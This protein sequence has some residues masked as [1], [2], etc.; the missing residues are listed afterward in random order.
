MQVDL[1]FPPFDYSLVVPEIGVPLLTANLR[2]AKQQVRQTDLN[3]E[4]IVDE[5][6]SLKTYARLFEQF[7][8][9][10]PTEKDAFVREPN[11]FL[12][13][14]C[15]QTCHV[16]GL[17]FQNGVDP[18]QPVMEVERRAQ[19]SCHLRP[20]QIR[21][22]WREDWRTDGGAGKLG[23]LNKPDALEL[24]AHHGARDPHFRARLLRLL[25]HYYFKPKSFYA[26]DLLTE[27]DSTNELLEPFYEA[28][29][30][31]LFSHS[32][33]DLFGISIWSSS[34]L[35]PA[36]ILAR[37]VKRLLPKTTLVAGGTWCSYAG[38]LITRV[39][40]LFEFFDGFV[41]HEGDRPLAGL[42]QAL[43]QGSDFDDLPGV[44]TRRSAQGASPPIQAPSS[45]ESLAQPVY[46]G[47]PL[48][49]YPEKRLVLRLAR[50]CYW[51]RCSMCSHIRLPHNRQYAS[52]KN[53]GLSQ[54][55]LASIATHIQH[56]RNE[57]GIE[58]FTTADNL[59]SPRVMLQLCE[60]NEGLQP[61]FKWTSLARFHPEYTADFCRQLAR[62]GCER[63][64]L[65]LET[66]SDPALARINKGIRMKTV[67]RGLRNLHAAGVAAMVFVAYYPGQS[68][69][70]YETTLRFLRDQQDL[71]PE[72]SLSRFHLARGT[73]A[74]AQ[75]E[76]L[77]ITHPGD[78][79]RY[80][81][82]F[83]L[84][85]TAENELS[86]EAFFELTR[87]YAAHLR[88][89]GFAFGGRAPNEK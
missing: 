24:L 7:A 69:K 73:R 8:P 34:Q 57:Y 52:P 20:H 80:L 72:I 4:F 28:R 43:E 19:K 10:S 25:N 63:L 51:G 64:D 23:R 49:V 42:V 86:D 74:W 60:L 54:A 89:G 35:L 12:A 82:V 41:L 13:Y 18:L 15:G 68:R 71:I 26:D 2:R 81:D 17:P 3:M 5:L 75:P 66:A 55:H 32:E 40:D 29:L 6:G 14:V 61:G 48:E 67:V 33:P 50:W 39:P 38:S 65:G 1:A 85:Y 88:G 70:T 16:R 87:H 37:L 9:I 45:F 56:A 58:R 36:M 84:P 31:D 21:S 83:D 76:S 77:G 62:G 11:R 44:L 30:E 27:L 59:I 22:D 47:F 53:A 79:A 46:D 78:G